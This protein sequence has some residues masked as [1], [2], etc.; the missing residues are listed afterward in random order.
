M[1]FV[2]E[3]EVCELD[4]VRCVSYGMYILASNSLTSLSLISS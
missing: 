4:N 1:V 2:L 3:Q